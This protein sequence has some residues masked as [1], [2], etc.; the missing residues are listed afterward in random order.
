MTLL[1]FVVFHPFTFE[2]TEQNRAEQNR[3]ESKIKIYA[4][5]NT[6]NKK[7][8]SVESLSL[9]GC[10]SFWLSNLLFYLSL[11]FLFICFHIL[12]HKPYY[13]IVTH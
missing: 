12:F 6:K 11:Y 3:T 1:S 13:T 7:Y 4:I 5:K 2:E 10:W 9:S 8:V